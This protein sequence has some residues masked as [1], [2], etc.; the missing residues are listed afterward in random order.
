[1]RPI[2]AWSVD[3]FCLWSVS[4]CQGNEQPHH[5]GEKNSSHRHIHRLI[6]LSCLTTKLSPRRVS[7]VG[8]SAGLGG[9]LAAASDILCS[10][11][12][13]VLVLLLRLHVEGHEPNGIMVKMRR[14]AVSH[15]PSL[16]DYRTMLSL[17]QR[18]LPSSFWR[19]PTLASKSI[20]IHVKPRMDLRIWTILRVMNTSTARHPTQP[21]DN[22]HFRYPPAGHRGY[23]RDYNDGRYNSVP[24][25]GSRLRRYV[26][27]EIFE[28]HRLVTHPLI[29]WHRAIQTKAVASEEFAQVPGTG[30]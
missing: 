15:F 4:S 29:A 3:S 19:T 22:G 12:Q 13:R 25:I 28:A 11:T 10:P 24:S 27:C 17:S 8:W 9:W 5:R 26:F 23:R 16:G 7:G 1:M 6:C 30:P 21:N 14:H 18:D 2:R 20:H